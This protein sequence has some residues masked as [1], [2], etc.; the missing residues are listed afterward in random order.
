MAT[1]FLSHD[2]GVPAGNARLREWMDWLGPPALL[3]A[4]GVVIGLGMMALAVMR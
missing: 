3:V 1:R 2:S 4:G